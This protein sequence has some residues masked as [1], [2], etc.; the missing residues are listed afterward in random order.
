MADTSLLAS[1]EHELRPLSL[2]AETKVAVERELLQHRVSTMATTVLRFATLFGVAP[3][4]R[5]DLTVNQFVMEMLVH[6]RLVVYGERF[7]RPYVHVRD[8]ASA[9]TTVLNAPVDLVKSQVFNVGHTD[10]NYRKMDLVDMIGRRVPGA[11]VEFVSVAD[12]PRDYKVSFERI[13]STL[14]FTPMRR[15]SDGIEEVARLI[16]SGVLGS[17]EDPAFSNVSEVSL[18]NVIAPPEPPACVP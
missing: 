11:T 16:E 17:V 1:E 13:R 4:M 18:S 7:W 6:R 10:E 3:R 5:F 8:A 2:Y 15:V 12:D 14:S 9:I